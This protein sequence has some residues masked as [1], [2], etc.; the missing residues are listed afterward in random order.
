MMLD[1]PR[2]V[3][4]YDAISGTPRG[5]GIRTTTRLWQCKLPASSEG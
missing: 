3:V 5:V 1:A 4:P 2:T